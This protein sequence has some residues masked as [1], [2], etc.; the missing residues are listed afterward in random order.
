MEVKHWRIENPG[1]E[2]STEKKINNPPEKI[3]EREIDL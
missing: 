3:G 1:K 2:Q